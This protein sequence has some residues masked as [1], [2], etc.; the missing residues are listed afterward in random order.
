M[1]TKQPE[2]TCLPHFGTSSHLKK[3]QLFSEFAGKSY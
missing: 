1:A 3:I 2:N